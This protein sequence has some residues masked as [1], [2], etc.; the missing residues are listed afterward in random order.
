MIG[1]LGRKAA[2]LDGT[3]KKEGTMTRYLYLKSFC[4]VLWN[5]SGCAEVGARSIGMGR[6]D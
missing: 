4:L 2:L 3:I 5:L 1:S 6:A